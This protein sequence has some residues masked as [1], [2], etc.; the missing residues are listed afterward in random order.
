MA[1]VYVTAVVRAPV[2]NVWDAIRDFNAL[3]DWHP[4]ITSSHIEEG[5]PAATVGCVR[6]FRLK[7]AAG[8]IREK[9]LALSDADRLFSYSILEAPLAVRNYVATLQLL[10]ITASQETFAQWQADFDVDPR[11]EEETVAVVTEVF[12]DG[13]AN[14]NRLLA[15]KT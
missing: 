12:Q 2:E 1:R 10:P 14:L 7:D 13:L 11:D 15:A 8:T 6:N 5:L 4:L 9:L 3:P